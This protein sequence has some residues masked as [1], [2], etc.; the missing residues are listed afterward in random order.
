[1]RNHLL[2][3][4]FLVVKQA[5]LWSYALILVLGYVSVRLSAANALY[6]SNLQSIWC[7]IFNF[8]ENLPT[9]PCSNSELLCQV[10]QLTLYYTTSH[11]VAENVRY[12]HEYGSPNFDDIPSSTV[13]TSKSLFESK[14]AQAETLPRPK[15]P[16][17][18]DNSNAKDMFEQR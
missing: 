2:F 11:S 16:T 7:N 4:I 1:M 13:H 15:T 9:L 17:R 12:A 8:R 18:E 10:K 5:G 6:P 3:R 14:L